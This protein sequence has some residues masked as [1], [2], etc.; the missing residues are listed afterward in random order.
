M[1]K[2]THLKDKL[3]SFGHCEAK[4]LQSND[5]PVAAENVKGIINFVVWTFGVREASLDSIV[6]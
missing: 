2:L 1:L 3:V 4:V 5:E 6:A